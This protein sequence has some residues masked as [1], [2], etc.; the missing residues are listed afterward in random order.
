MRVVGRSR[1]LS[2][3]P[4][5]GGGGGTALASRPN[6]GSGYWPDSSNTGYLNEPSYPGSLSD[7]TGGM[8]QAA[9]VAVAP[10]D[11]STTSYKRMLG[12]SLITGTNVTFVGCVFEGTLPNV[13]MVDIQATTKITFRYCTFKP[14]QLS[15]P[16]GNN[17]TITSA[18]TSPGTPY[19]QSWQYVSTRGQTIQCVFDH[20]DFWGGAGTETTPGVSAGAPTTYTDCYF[21]DCADNDGSGGS[22]YHHDGFGPDSDGG[23]TDTLINRCTIASLGN[24]NA[25]ALQG[26]ATY[27]RITVQGCYLSGFGWTVSLGASTPWSCTNVLFQDNVFSTELA[28]LYGP[29]YGGIWNSGGGT[30]TW[31]RNFYHVRTGDMSTALSTAAHG[32]YWWPGDFDAHDT[33]YS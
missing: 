4:S 9:A 12:Q 31:R 24:T 17:G 22:N 25:I 19:S 21:H 5:Q 1:V 23:H 7:F 6:D 2:G 28:L 27:N 3:T 29:L 20:C 15:A 10:G 18:K 16:P 8:S 26:S 30:N 33:D 14:N 13:T 32:K 11:N